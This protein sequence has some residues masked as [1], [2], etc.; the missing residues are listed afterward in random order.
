MAA[1]LAQHGTSLRPS[2]A[3]TDASQCAGLRVRRQVCG[4]WG[5]L[6]SNG[7]RRYGVVSALTAVPA[8]TVV[9]APTA[10]SASTAVAARTVVACVVS[11]YRE[12]STLVECKVS[13][14]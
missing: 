3:Y 11:L 8:L 13:M 4:V 14:A 2:H 1:E 6:A 12:L 7:S 10:V 9:S 5:A